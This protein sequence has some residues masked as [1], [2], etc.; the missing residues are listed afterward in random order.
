[1][2]KNVALS[3][4][5]GHT[6][7]ELRDL[8]GAVNGARDFHAWAKEQGYESYLLTHAEVS[9]KAL[10]ER[11]KS[12]VD[13]L[14]ERFIIYFAGHGIQQTLNTPIWLLPGWEQ[15][16]NEAVN[17]NLSL[18]HAKRSGLRQIAI[19]ADACR[20]TV[21]GGQTV[22][23]S[24]I[25]P[26][27]V[28]VAPGIGA[29]WDQFYSTLLGEGAQ[30]VVDK[31]EIEAFG[32]F[33]DCLM[34]A[35]HG[36]EEKAI[37]TRNSRVVSSEKL[38][39]YLE[40][41]VPEESG[42]I[43]NVQFPDVISGWRSPNDVYTEL[44]TSQKGMKAEPK[45][46]TDWPRTAIDIDSKSRDKI[47]EAIA[48]ATRVEP[49]D[50]DRMSGKELLEALIAAD[51]GL[52]KAAPDKVWEARRNADEAAS[53]KA[54]HYYETTAS[55]LTGPATLSSLRVEGCVPVSFVVRQGD[56]ASLEYASVSE[57]IHAQTKKP[58]PI[59]I[60]SNDGN[61][62]GSCILPGFEGYVVVE[63][64]LSASLNYV[65]VEEELDEEI[66][67][68]VVQVVSRWTALMQQGRVGDYDELKHFEKFSPSLGIIAAYAYDRVGNLEAIDDIAIADY[69]AESRALRSQP[70]TFDVA[71][72]STSLPVSTEVAGAFPF[73]TQGWS[74]LDQEKEFVRPE[75]FALRQGLLPALWT[76]LRSE[77]GNK[78]ATLL[79]QEE[80]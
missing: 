67:D 23:G 1:V 29:Q 34:R 15:D 76:T 64:G 12:V 78:A 50:K 11:I 13:E 31:D 72:L 10:K 75:I 26:K 28:P 49:S 55:S 21:R 69:V 65:P 41:S 4:G 25:F 63:N 54:Q 52:E 8:P 44:R 16:D 70:I 9:V 19:F 43:A 48:S 38:A 40:E 57:R 2:G 74:I 79:R 3:I 30:E 22:Q 68:E 27:S 17:V 62:I 80:I 33:T 36:A 14:A 35:L 7:G 47:F 20:S 51:P 66:Y 59:L 18:H 39:N 71:L 5:I 73:M 32:I 77:E 61:W 37:D 24:S 60:E 46:P 45:F 58:I 42:K 56:E 53:A 6:G